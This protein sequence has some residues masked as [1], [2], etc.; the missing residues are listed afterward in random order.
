MK[1][2]VDETHNALDNLRREQRD[3]RGRIRPALPATVCYTCMQGA[4]G[5]F[6]SKYPGIEMHVHFSTRWIDLYLEPF[7]LEIRTGE[8]LDSNLVARPLIT[9]RMG[10]YA[11]PE[12]LQ[13]YDKPLE[14]YDLAD[15]SYIHM[16]I[17]PR[18]S[19]ELRGKHRPWTM[20]RDAGVKHITCH[21]QDV[22]F[23]LPDRICQP[24][25]KS[26]EFRVAFSAVKGPADVPVRGVEDSHTATQPPQRRSAL[27]ILHASFSMKSCRPKDRLTPVAPQVILLAASVQTRS[28]WS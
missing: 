9:P 24:S 25:Q 17:F 18:R 20:T 6:A 11:S 5:A 1:S 26:F 19:L 27:R 10:L 2:F 3:H 4:L 7:D 28:I 22:D 14:P 21:Q 12:L 16:T 8:L 15:L 13:R 23:I